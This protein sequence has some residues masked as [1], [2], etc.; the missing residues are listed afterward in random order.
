MMMTHTTDG[1]LPEPS[2]EEV[3]I[4]RIV[5]GEAFEDDWREFERLATDDAKIWERLARAQREHDRL[6]RNVSDAIAIAE[7]VDIPSAGVH[8]FA[9]MARIRQY[10]GWAAAATRAC[11]CSCF[12]CA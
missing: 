10:S 6:V 11:A 2:R 5:D 8:S 7:L 4:T 12:C 9:L 1:R 3:L